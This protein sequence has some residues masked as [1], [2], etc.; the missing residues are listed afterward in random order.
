MSQATPPIE[1]DPTA[2]AEARRL[3]KLLGGP[4]A[5]AD[6]LAMDR[7]NM[8]RIHSGKRHASPTLLRRLADKLEATDV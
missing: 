4:I 2:H 1:Q 6:A 8:Q 3:I 5:A 7:R